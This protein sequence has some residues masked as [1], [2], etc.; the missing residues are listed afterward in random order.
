MKTFQTLIS[1]IVLCV[2]AALVFQ[3]FRT[4]SLFFKVDTHQKN[5]EDHEQRLVALKLENETQDVELKK[6]EELIEEHS[7]SIR[8][9]FDEIYAQKQNLGELASHLEK[10][11]GRLEALQADASS[12][13]AEITELREAISSFKRLYD[14]Q[15]EENRRL[16]RDLEELIQK[17]AE[18]ELRL[19]ALEKLLQGQG[20]QPINRVEGIQ[21]EERLASLRAL[22][23]TR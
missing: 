4:A 9:N 15:A 1:M 8:E 19:R 10:L 6:H 7:Q 5:L 16:K 14:H 3:I 11:E 23:E 13:A 20:P 2:A 21:L 17:D 22:I 18:V 12:S